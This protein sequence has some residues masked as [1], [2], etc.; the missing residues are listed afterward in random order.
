[1][2]VFCHDV[3]DEKSRACPRFFCFECG[4]WCGMIVLKMPAIEMNHVHC[5]ETIGS[6]LVRAFYIYFVFF[7]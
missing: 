1:M 5:R 6:T 3:C 7:M 2:A 4:M